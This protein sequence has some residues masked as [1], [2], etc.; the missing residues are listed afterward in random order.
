MEESVNNAVEE[1]ISDHGT[2]LIKTKTGSE[3]VE[4]FNFL[5]PWYVPFDFN[6]SAIEAHVAFIGTLFYAIDGVVFDF[7]NSPEGV[8]GSKVVMGVHEFINYFSRDIV[9]EE[10]ESVSRDDI[11]SFIVM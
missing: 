2:I 9:V 3:R 8:H 6:K 1:Y 11:E 10:F 7:W 5:Q 4:L